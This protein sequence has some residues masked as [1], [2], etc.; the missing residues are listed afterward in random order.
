M[1]LTSREFSVAPR[2]TS[3]KRPIEIR[4]RW[5]RPGRRQANPAFKENDMEPRHICIAKRML[6]GT[7]PD[8]LRHLLD[9]AAG[10]IERARESGESPTGLNSRQAIAAIIIAWKLKEPRT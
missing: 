5:R 6:G 9:E 8:S 2:G 10:M 7:V 3:V 1:G 4:I